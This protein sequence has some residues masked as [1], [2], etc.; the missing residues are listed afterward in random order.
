MGLGLTLMIALGLS[1]VQAST[2]TLNH[3]QMVRQRC[4]AAAQASL[5]SLAAT[6]NT[7]DKEQCD[8]LWPGITLQVQSRPGAGEFAGLQ[9]ATVTAVGSS[10]GKEISV[11]LSRYLPQPRAAGVTTASQ[12]AS[13]S[14]APVEGISHD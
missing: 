1:A 3:H 2:G 4:I 14:L 5:D 11:K 12:P 9:Q 7:I 13:A 10:R 8:R 6:G